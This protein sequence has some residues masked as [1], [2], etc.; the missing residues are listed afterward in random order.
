M[1]AKRTARRAADGAR[2]RSGRPCTGR[3]QHCNGGSLMIVNLNEASTVASTAMHMLWR[4][5]LTR[6]RAPPG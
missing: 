6:A 2:R 5:K 4:S 1:S 3:P